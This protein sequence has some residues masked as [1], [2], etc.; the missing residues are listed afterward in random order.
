MGLPKIFLSPFVLNIA[1]LMVPKHSIYSISASHGAGSR[2]GVI[3]ILK[4]MEF[5]PEIDI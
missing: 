1:L 3:E 4:I 2:P 5:H